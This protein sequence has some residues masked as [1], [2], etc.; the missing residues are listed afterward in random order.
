MFALTSRPALFSVVHHDLSTRLSKLS[1]PDQV[2]QTC[3]QPWFD[4]VIQFMTSEGT[5]CT[6]F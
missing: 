6:R 5:L 2:D 4:H 1:G 3:G